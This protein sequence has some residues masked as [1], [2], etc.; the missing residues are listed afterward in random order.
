[1]PDLILL[2]IAMPAMGGERLLSVLRKYQSLSDVRVVFHSG[3]EEDELREMAESF[4]ADGFIK[5]SLDPEVLPK[6]V[7][8]FLSP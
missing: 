3:K 2:D 1:Q 4:G 7:A 8:E 5:K 6:Q